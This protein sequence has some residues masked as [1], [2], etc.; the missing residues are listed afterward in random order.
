MTEL[1]SGKGEGQRHEPRWGLLSPCSAPEG[2]CEE[3]VSQ[4]PRLLKSPHD[5]LIL[6]MYRSWE[7]NNLDGKLHRQSWE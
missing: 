7:G 2:S 4:V 6:F 5:L 3:L 1:H